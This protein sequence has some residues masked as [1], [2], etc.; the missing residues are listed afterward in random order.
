MGQWITG[1]LRWMNKWMNEQ[2]KGCRLDG[3]MDRRTSRIKCMGLKMNKWKNNRK[4]E[5]RTNWEMS[6]RPTDEFMSKQM[7]K[8]VRINKQKSHQTNMNDWKTID[9]VHYSNYTKNIYLWWVSWFRFPIGQSN[10]RLPIVKICDNEWNNFQSL[11]KAHVVS[12]NSTKHA[13]GSSTGRKICSSVE[14]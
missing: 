2:T 13:I 9:T 4:N 5:E 12:K 1:N 10:Q 8:E 14:V 11:S 6:N 7:N 3:C